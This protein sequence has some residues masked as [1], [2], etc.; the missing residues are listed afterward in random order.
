MHCCRN[1]LFYS[2][3][4]SVA[5]LCVCQP[6]QKDCWARAF[7]AVALPP[8]TGHSTGVA[9]TNPD[10]QMNSKC[11]KEVVNMTE[12]VYTENW[13]Q[14]PN[15]LF[16]FELSKFLVLWNIRL[17]NVLCRIIEYFKLSG[18][19]KDHWVLAYDLQALCSPKRH[20]ETSKLQYLPRNFLCHFLVFKVC[21]HKIF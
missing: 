12:K 6:C 3:Q 7:I 10:G 5:F 9:G 15:K 14:W 20:R 1:S 11:F 2:S 17:Y 18:I 13:M 16:S 19:H 8:P 21:P 4:H